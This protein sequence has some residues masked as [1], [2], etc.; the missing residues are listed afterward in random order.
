VHDHCGELDDQGGQDAALR[1]QERLGRVVE[2]ETPDGWHQL[3][4]VIPYFALGFFEL[5][6]DVGE[7]GDDAFGDVEERGDE[8][9]A[10]EEVDK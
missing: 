8:E 10:E 7:E 5:G 6:H 3:V 1:L 2:S 9:G 4:E